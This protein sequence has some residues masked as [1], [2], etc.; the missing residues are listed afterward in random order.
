MRSLFFLAFLLIFTSCEQTENC[1]FYMYV[2]MIA[3]TIIH[4]P[5][6]VIQMTHYLEIIKL[7]IYMYAGM[8][9]VI[10]ESILI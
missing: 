9:A 3:E 10:I 2:G 5:H 4:L 1:D 6:M 7:D 8:I